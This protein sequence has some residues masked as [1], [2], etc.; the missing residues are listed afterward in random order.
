MK[1]LQIIRQDI[2]FNG[3]RESLRRDLHSRYMFTWIILNAG[4]ENGFV[5]NCCL[6]YRSTS[7][8]ADY[9]HNMNKDNFTKWVTVKLIPNLSRPK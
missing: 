2:D 8:S 1:L 3:R 4:G 9:Y 7:I 6:V 5:P